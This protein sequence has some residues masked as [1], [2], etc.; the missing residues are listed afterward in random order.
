MK[1]E[2]RE[3]ENGEANILNKVDMGFDQSLDGKSKPT[4]KSRHESLRPSSAKQQV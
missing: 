3:A 1:G 2:L 4:N